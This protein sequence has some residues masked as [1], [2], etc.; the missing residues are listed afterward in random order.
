M[1]ITTQWTG[2]C[3][4]V[5]CCCHKLHL[6]VRVNDCARLNNSGNAWQTEK[7]TWMSVPNLVVGSSALTGFRL[8]FNRLSQA[9]IAY[10]HICTTVLRT[11][12][13]A[14]QSWLCVMWFL[15]RPS[16]MICCTCSTQMRPSP[17]RFWNVQMLNTSRAGVLQQVPPKSELGVENTDVNWFTPLRFGNNSV[18]NMTTKIYWV[19]VRFLKIRAVTVYFMVSNIPPAC[20]YFHFVDVADKASCTCL[21]FEGLHG[22]YWLITC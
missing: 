20:V 16:L 18:Q 5:S 12:H 4:C 21:G 17:R 22:S 13:F 7:Q 9:V 10:V 19:I 2:K 11:V 3:W 6:N 14:V 15:G 8:K 1:K